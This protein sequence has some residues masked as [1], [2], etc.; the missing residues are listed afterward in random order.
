MSGGA[1][2]IACIEDVGVPVD[3]LHDYMRRVQDIL[4]EHETT[5]SFL[6][7]A[8]AGQVHTRPF[9][10]LQKP[11]DVSRLWSI[12]EEGAR[13]GPGI[14]RHRQHASMAP[15][16]RGL[17][18]LRGSMAR[19][20][21]S[22]ARSKRSSIRRTSSIR[23][24]SSIPIRDQ[25]SRP[26]RYARFPRRSRPVR[27]RS[28]WQPDEVQA[29]GESLQRL[30]RI[31]GPNCPA[32]GCARFSAP[33]K[34]RPPRRAPRRICCAI[35]LQPQANGLQLG[36]EE[37]REVADL[38]VHCKMCA[39]ECPAHI[40]IPNLMLE[41][42]AANVAE[43]GMDRTRL[44]L[45]PPGR[46]AALG[47][48]RVVSWPISPCAAE[49]SRWLLDKLFGL[50]RERRAA[51]LRSAV[52][53]GPGQTARLDA[54]AKRQPGPSSSTSSICTRTTSSRKSRRP[55]SPFCST[56]A[57]TCSSRPDQRGSGLEALVHGD[58]ETAR[59]TGA[60]KICASWSRPP[61]PIGRSSAPSQAPP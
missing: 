24:R 44:V 15:A 29:G 18:G 45:R 22:C 2:P 51:A 56:T 13:A 57:S 27:L 20:I 42:K 52:I 35:L 5:A 39:M 60:T 58:V 4:Q 17:R 48:R 9:L 54:Q 50:S 8:G 59:E 7:H 10:D 61:A 47:Q 21:R 53:H 26:L 19:S 40:N 55:R 37:V 34:P 49:P 14:G 30:R 33:R 41:A 32:S 3:A 46:R 43:H 36:S 11:D 16:W 25:A 6:V 31:A 28:N 12:A 1:Q 23:A 38:C